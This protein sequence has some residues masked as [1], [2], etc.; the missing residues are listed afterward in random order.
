[1]ETW[2]ICMCESRPELCIYLHIKLVFCSAGGGYWQVGKQVK[3]SRP[4]AVADP[5]PNTLQHSHVKLKPPPPL[6]LW[7][8]NCALT[9]NHCC[10]QLEALNQSKHTQVFSVIY[11][12]KFQIFSGSGLS[13]VTLTDWQN[14]SFEDITLGSG[15]CLFLQTFLSFC[16]LHLRIETDLTP[17]AHIGLMAQTEEVWLQ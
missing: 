10:V 5:L 14:K 7:C 17:V 2:L 13:N 1:M 12:E 15:L 16:L 6:S 8:L 11:S 9:S 4:P 3:R